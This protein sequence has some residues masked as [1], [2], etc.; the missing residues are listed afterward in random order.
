MPA[1]A[2]PAIPGRS[3]DKIARPTD[4]KQTVP[5]GQIRPARR[6]NQAAD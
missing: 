2:H 3:S 4:K 6:Q 1:L 5:A